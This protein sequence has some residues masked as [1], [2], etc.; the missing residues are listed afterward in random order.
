V[1]NVPFTNYNGRIVE[2]VHI[3]AF[4]VRTNGIHGTEVLLFI[5]DIG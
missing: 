3:E 4:T 1:R 2:N 5:D